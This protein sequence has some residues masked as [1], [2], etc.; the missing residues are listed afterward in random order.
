MSSRKQIEANRQNARKPTG[1]KT[2]DGK[3][4]EARKAA[5]ARWG[6]RNR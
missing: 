3:T 1:P 6:N 4:H 5:L 2:A